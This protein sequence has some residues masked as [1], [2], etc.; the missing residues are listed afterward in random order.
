[1]RIVF[2]IRAGIINAVIIID[3]LPAVSPACSWE[4]TRPVLAD[5]SA[6]K[7][8]IDQCLDDARARTSTW[9]IVLRSC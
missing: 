3:P 2:A 8:I 5:A 9:L 1:M 4:K 7:G 6:A